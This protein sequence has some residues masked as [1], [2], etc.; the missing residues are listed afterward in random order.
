M[1][2]KPNN[3]SPWY[4]FNGEY[5][6]NAPLFYSRDELTWLNTLEEKFTLIKSELDDFVALKK[7]TIEPYFNTELTHNKNDWK[8]AVFYFWGNKNEE[9]CKHIPKLNAMLN[10]LP[11]FLSAGLSILKAN[12]IIKPHMGDTDAVIRIHLGLKIPAELPKC[13]IKVGTEERS[14]QEG[15]LLAFC[16]AHKHSVWNNT[17]EDRYLLIID[18]LRPEFINQREDVARNVQSLLKLQELENKLSIIKH[19]PNPVRGIIRKTFC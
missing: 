9:N 4:S 8:L 19:L 3:R 10:Q 16:D 12:T 5:T 14:W 6:G 18:V 1:T 15:K 7:E 17:N 13:G 2:T 11:G